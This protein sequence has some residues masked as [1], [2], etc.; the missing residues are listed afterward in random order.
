MIAISL[1]FFERKGNV[2]LIP[3]LFSKANIY[4]YSHFLWSRLVNEPDL[5]PEKWSLTFCQMVLIFRASVRV[6][7][8][9]N[10]TGASRKC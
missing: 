4:F 5:H 7:V 10:D 1:N 2:Y 6:R 8:R 3:T 9:V